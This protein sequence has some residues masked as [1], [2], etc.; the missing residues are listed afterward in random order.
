MKACVAAAACAAA[1]ASTTLGDTVDH[2]NASYRADGI[3][4]PRQ[5]TL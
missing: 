2:A 4:L 1:D 5:R 3:S